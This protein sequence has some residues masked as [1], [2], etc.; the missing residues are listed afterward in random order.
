MEQLVAEQW[1][2]TE[3]AHIEQVEVLELY[4]DIIVHQEVVKLADQQ[5]LV[6]QRIEVE[7]LQDIMAHAA[8]HQEHLPTEVLE[9]ELAVMVV[10][11]DLRLEAL[12][13]Q[14]IQV[15]AVEVVT[16]ALQ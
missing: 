15:A 14:V 10:V 1:E 13:D 6:A 5:R 12:Q 8:V 7:H 16:D 11:L 9:V 2:L 4:L 3:I